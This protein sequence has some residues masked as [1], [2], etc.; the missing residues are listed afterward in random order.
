MKRFVQAALVAGAV[1]LSAAGCC[2]WCGS[3]DAAP[4]PAYSGYST[5]TPVVARP[6]MPAAATTG[7]GYAGKGSPQMIMPTGQTGSAT[8][9]GE[10]PSTYKIPGN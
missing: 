6:G 5:P 9:T 1:V 2:S 7:Y 4:A 3:K 8:V 10:M